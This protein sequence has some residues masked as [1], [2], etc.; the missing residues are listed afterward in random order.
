MWRLLSGDS[1]ESRI[2]KAYTGPLELLEHCLKTLSIMQV[3]IF[4]KTAP[5][6]RK[7]VKEHMIC[8]GVS[9]ELI[10]ELFRSI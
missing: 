4:P 10:D 7:E 2:A 6:T 9:E 8:N 3:N 5:Q 1:I